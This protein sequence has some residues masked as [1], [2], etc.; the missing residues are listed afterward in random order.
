M[1]IRDRSIALMW[2]TPE[3]KAE[4][5]TH[6]RFD[7]PGLLIFM[8]TVLALMVVLIFGRQIGWTSLATLALASVAVVG[9]TVFFLVER[10]RTA[11]FI[12]FALFKNTTFTGATLSN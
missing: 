7:V 5:T 10:S 6:R 12:D 3:S 1:C 4:V 2:R 11:P 9:T 8:V